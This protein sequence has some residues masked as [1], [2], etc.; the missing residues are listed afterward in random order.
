MMCD[1]CV[2]LSSSFPLHY[3][4]Q[5]FYLCFAMQVKMYLFFFIKINIMNKMW[6]FF[7][8]KDGRFFPSF[9]M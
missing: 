2:V 6:V 8:V 7:K 1:Y 3:C 9:F 4:S 5:F